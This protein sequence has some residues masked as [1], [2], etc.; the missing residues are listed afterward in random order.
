[1]NWF[2]Q[3]SPKPDLSASSPK[4]PAP[5]GRRAQFGP[6]QLDTLTE[7]LWKDASRVRLQSQP[8]RILV[9]LI[10]NPNDLVTR[11]SIRAAIWPEESSLGFDNSINASMN[12]LRAAIE[13]SAQS[14]RYLETLARRGYRFI[15]T[16]EWIGE[17]PASAPSGMFQRLKGVANDWKWQVI[18]ASLVLGLLAALLVAQARLLS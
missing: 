12:K 9:L 2:W 16:V 13:D 15:G 18:M 1:M 11:E 7:E 8:F 10:S 14:P 3:T 5:K 6:F 17:S 4:R